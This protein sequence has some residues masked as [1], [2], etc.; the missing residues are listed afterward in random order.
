[1]VDSVPRRHRAW[2][3]TFCMTMVMGA[4]TALYLLTAGEIFVEDDRLVIICIVLICIACFFIGPPVSFVDGIYVVDLVD[5]SEVSFASG[6]VGSMGYIGPIVHNL[7]LPAW[8]KE[9]DANW[10]YVYLWALVCAGISFTS[11]IVYWLYD[12]K[13]RKV[14]KSENSW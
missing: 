4:L 2:L 7:F 11:S 12:L 8:V 14:A 13:C 3:N 9:D 10:Q 1:M 5:A 6:V